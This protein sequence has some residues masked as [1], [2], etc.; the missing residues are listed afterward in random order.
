MYMFM[1]LQTDF[2]ALKKVDRI[3]VMCITSTLYLFLVDFVCALRFI[4]T[5][6]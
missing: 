5:S 4:V 2:V 3:I 6:W 1:Q